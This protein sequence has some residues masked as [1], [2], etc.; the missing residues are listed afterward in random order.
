MTKTSIK[1]LKIK[2]DTPQTSCQ[3]SLCASCCFWQTF[4]NQLLPEGCICRS[5]ILHRTEGKLHQCV[6][7]FSCVWSFSGSRHLQAL[8]LLINRDHLMRPIEHNLLTDV[9]FSRTRTLHCV[10]LIHSV[11]LEQSCASLQCRQNSETD[12]KKQNKTSRLLDASF[13]WKKI[14]NTLSLLDSKTVKVCLPSGAWQSNQHIHTPLLLSNPNTGIHS[15][16]W[17]DKDIKTLR[18]IKNVENLS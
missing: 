17:A 11:K 3:D 18:Y 7:L 1:A 16:I 13:I 12:K 14:F 5:K 8:R 15:T 4:S 2:Q 6:S 9:S 10:Y